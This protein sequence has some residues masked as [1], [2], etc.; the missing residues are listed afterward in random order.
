MSQQF[1]F[2]TKIRSPGKVGII[3]PQNIQNSTTEGTEYTEKTATVP[4]VFSVVN[5]E[6]I[7][8]PRPTH[9]FKASFLRIPNVKLAS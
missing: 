8:K 9:D 7:K 5:P 4:S 2:Q 3:Q 6:E 1:N